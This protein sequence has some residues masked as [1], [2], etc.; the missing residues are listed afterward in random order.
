MTYGIINPSPEQ[1]RPGNS[2]PGAGSSSG[3]SDSG[4]CCQRTT[5]DPGG[6]ASG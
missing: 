3:T 6:C 2:N 1:L 4:R 5:L